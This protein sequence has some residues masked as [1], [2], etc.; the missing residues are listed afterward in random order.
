MNVHQ[1]SDGDWLL[2]PELSFLGDETLAATQEKES[3]SLVSSGL[4]SLT[5]PLAAR[6]EGTA[7]RGLSH[8]QAF[9]TL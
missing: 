1:G 5:Y 4:P 2:Q 9:C 6:N 3:S 8:I 7:T